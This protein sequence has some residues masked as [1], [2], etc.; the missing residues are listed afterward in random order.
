[1]RTMLS[2]TALP[3]IICVTGMLFLSIIYN[4]CNQKAPVSRPAKPVVTDSPVIE[5]RVETIGTSATPEASP[6]SPVHNAAETTVRYDEMVQ[7]YGELA[8]AITDTTTVTSS[9]AVLLDKFEQLKKNSDPAMQYFVHHRSEF[10]KA[11]VKKIQQDMDEMGKEM[12]VILNA[13]KT[14]MR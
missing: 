13:L 9:M 1:M 6:V 7:G 8:K 4:S 5:S 14:G 12:T 3:K 10:S 2:S 11:Q